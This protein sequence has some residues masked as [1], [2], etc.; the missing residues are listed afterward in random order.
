MLYCAA[1]VIL[2]LAGGCVTAPRVAVT[3]KPGA[4]S[5]APAAP[6]GVYHV[7]AKGQT[8]WRI[9]RIYGVEIDELARV[10]AVTNASGLAVGQKLFIP[11]KDAE[12]VCRI[13]KDE[14]FVWPV[15]GTVIGRF[16][17]FAGTQRLEA[18]HIA[19]S[20]SRQ[21]VASRS[22]TVAFV[23]RDFLDLG[24][25]VIIDHGDGFLT[26]YGRNAE[27]LVKPGDVIARGDP[28]ATV[29]QAGKDS[30]SFLYFEIRKGHIPRDPFF[31]L[32]R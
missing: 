23:H 28:I 15:Q 7:V 4:G 8:L 29:G 19:P 11:G 9:S 17:A 24:K 10:N 13:V 20:R 1:G 14:E 27:V 30:R 31:Y 5:A 3:A 2:A 16:G 6:K 32:S 26:V 22:G 21:V 18:L 25:T 12:S